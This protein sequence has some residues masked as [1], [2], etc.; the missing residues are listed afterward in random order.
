MT[1]FP[2]V[3]MYAACIYA[4]CIHAHTR[5]VHAYIYDAFCVHSRAHAACRRPY[6]KGCSHPSISMHPSIDVAQQRAWREDMRL[7]DT[8]FVQAILSTYVW[9]WV[10]AHVCVCVGV[11]V[12]VCVGAVAVLP[13]C[14]LCSWSVREGDR[15]ARERDAETQT[16]CASERA[17][18]TKREGRLACSRIRVCTKCGTYMYAPNSRKQMQSRTA[19]HTN[20][21]AALTHPR[22]Q[23][24]SESMCVCILHGLI[25]GLTHTHVHTH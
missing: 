12:C 4:C 1:R 3:R 21:R 7:P 22:V 20:I 2:R 6:I 16:E 19:T 13:A 11:C 18:R 24:E 15:I 23:R 25:C 9:V 14:S 10:W 5:I 17:S 8:I